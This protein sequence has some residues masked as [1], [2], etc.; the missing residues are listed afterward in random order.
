MTLGRTNAE[1]I[2]ATLLCVAVLGL[3][4]GC[5]ARQRKV[6]DA[7]P[8][9]LVPQQAVTGVSSLG[10]SPNTGSEATTL[11]RLK[12]DGSQ[13]SDP[14]AETWQTEKL[15]EAAQSQLDKLAKIMEGEKPISATEL[16]RFLAADFRCS[17]PASELAVVFQDSALKVEVPPTQRERQHQG[18][19]GLAHVLSELRG[20]PHTVAAS[21]CK[22]K[23]FR[24]LRTNDELSTTARWDLLVET[25]AEAIQQ[26]AVW[27]CGWEMTED[28]PPRLR[29]IEIVAHQRVTRVRPQPL[30]ADCTE[31]VLG[32]NDSYHQQLAYGLDH[33]LRRLPLYDGI[34]ATSYHGLAVGDA[35]G[36]GLD[37]VYVCQPGGISGG[38]PNRLYVQQPDGSALDVSARAGL[39]WLTES[40]SALFLDL[41]DDADQDL[42]VATIAG[43][44]FAENDGKGQFEQ[45]VFKLVPEAPPLSLAAA[46]FDNDGDLDIYACCYARRTSTGEN[47]RPMPYHD[48]NNGGRNVLFRNDR[49]W[50]F[51]DV[52]QQVGLDQNNRRFSF[53][54][55]WEDFDNDGDQDLYVANDFGRNNLYRN[56]R[57]QFADIADQAGVEDMSAGMSVSWG[58]VNNDG[59][60]DL[61]VGNMW[62]SAGNRIAYQNRFLPAGADESALA[63]FRRH[64]RGNSL[65]VNAS[66][67]GAAR[68]EDHSADARVAMA[69]W[70]WS[71]VFVDINNDGW[72]DL[73]VANGYITQED[74]RDL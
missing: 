45:R 7:S 10:G 55:A 43:L 63:G 18:E 32:S 33:W 40:H 58:D 3:S 20:Q 30:F 13:T 59:R 46:D 9:R 17:S 35:N 19:E 70:A 74:E 4:A 36:D 65:F 28:Q 22:F 26:S 24:V 66:Q 47:G 52:T 2:A 25:S 54:C 11:I 67:G 1:S 37:D 41:D 27:V 12:P 44:I 61:Y 39:D 53:A 29:S 50:R 73:L 6:A 68:F 71:S 38:L 62:S 14:D 42:V 49:D 69:G 8:G 21:R 72:Q 48:A 15:G 31:A 60:M 57:G 64:A 56:D 16:S 34:I 5:G 51:T 23:T